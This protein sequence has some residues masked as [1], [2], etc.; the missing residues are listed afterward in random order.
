MSVEPA[1]VKAGSLEGRGQLT[2]ALAVAELSRSRFRAEAGR[3]P[4][5][6]QAPR[7]G[8]AQPGAE[9]FDVAE[10][11]IG[12]GR[13]PCRTGPVSAACGVTRPA[14]VFRTVSAHVGTRNNSV[15]STR[16]G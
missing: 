9:R 2:Q 7:R 3:S 12:H 8:E 10:I 15:I 6:C 4:W 1:V 16:T 13:D 5:P 14:H 11:T